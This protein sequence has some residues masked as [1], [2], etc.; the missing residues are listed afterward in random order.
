VSVMPLSISLWFLVVANKYSARAAKFKQSQA[1]DIS[2]RVK[3][4]GR[5]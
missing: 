1:K 3:P 5:K 4:L 2:K